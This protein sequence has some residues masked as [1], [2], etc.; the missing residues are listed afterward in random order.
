MSRTTVSTCGRFVV[1]SDLYVDRDVFEALARWAADREL[2]IQDGLQLA[3]C[4]FRDG[5][6]EGSGVPATAASPEVAASTRG[7]E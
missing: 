3:L 7:L 1:L 4:A 6:F 5:T 2:R